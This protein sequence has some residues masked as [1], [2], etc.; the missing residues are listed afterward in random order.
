M[1]RRR[2]GS[3]LFRVALDQWRVTRDE[4]EDYRLAAYE[5]A[6][7][8]TNGA[9]LNARGKRAGI[10]S[11]DLFIGP[12]VRARAYASE[13]LIEHWAKHPRPVFARFESTAAKGLIA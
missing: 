12:D 9:M 10:D 5:R 4:F 1:S 11:Y 13:E 6:I 8:E 2:I 7:R 3:E